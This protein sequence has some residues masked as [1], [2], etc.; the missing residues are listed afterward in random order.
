MET[1]LG[2]GAVVLLI[3]ATA[4]F[5]ASE[6]AMV[7]VERPQLDLLAQ[8]SRR[9]RLAKRLLA[10]LSFHLSGAQLGITVAALLLGFIAEPTIGAAV[11]D[12]FGIES[13]TASVAIA[14]AL[15]SALTTV[16]GEL[17][18]KGLAIARP[19]RTAIA[20]APFTHAYGIVAKPVIAVLDSTANWLVRLLG[21]E[22]ADEL[23]SV[24]SL[25]ELAILIRSSGEQGTIRDEDRE[26]LD[27]TI[28]FSGKDAADALVPRLAMTAVPK[29]ATV[30]ELSALAIE[31]GHSR[32]PVYGS[33]LDDIVGVV[34]A[35]DVYRLRG[36]E[37][38][39]ATVEQIMREPTVVPE[40]RP[41]DDIL[42]DMRSAQNRFAVVV[43]EHG[44]TAGLITLED[45]VEEIV[46]DI[47]DEYD[48]TLRL[49]TP[50]GAGRYVLDA[51][52]HHDEV[53]ALV[54]FDMPEGEYETLA[55]F[56]LDRF[57]YIPDVGDR[58][59]YAGW[60]FEVL[61]RDR[62]RVSSVAVQPP[63]PRRDGAA[64]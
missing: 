13:R 17:V 35:K 29:T 24:R 33:D 62:L 14:L 43:D 57:G 23:R 56:L 60:D 37:R 25:D 45:L 36:P 22:P 61:E 54:G 7:A 59:E 39:A 19:A 9:A 32:I 10:R 31:T 50:L 51:S 20:T 27:R 28:R 12:V 55:G 2:F 6:F 47:E 46:G 4:V 38:A 53:E 49:S 40:T 64:R 48:P 44:G 63:E 21:V 30:G 34:E 3:A 41:L 5:V 42:M 52:L 8:T 18:P 58:V 1:L 11:E 16:V 15:A 26:L